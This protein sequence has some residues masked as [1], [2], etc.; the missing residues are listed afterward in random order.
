MPPFVS[1][2]SQELLN[3]RARIQPERLGEAEHPVWVDTRMVRGYFEAV[4]LRELCGER[5]DLSY[6]TKTVR[7]A[8]QG[9]IPG[10]SF[11]REGEETLNDYFKQLVATAAPARPGTEVEPEPDEATAAP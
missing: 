2:K 6:M 10:F 5:E 4:K 11:L 1:T 8:D 7:N 9:E 3:E